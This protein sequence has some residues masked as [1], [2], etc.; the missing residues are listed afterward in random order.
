VPGERERVALDELRR[1][2]E[3]AR[4]L[5][6]VE[7]EAARVVARQHAERRDSRPG[8]L[9]GRRAAEPQ[10]EQALAPVEILVQ[11]DVRLGDESVASRA[12]LFALE[13][14]VRAG[15][16]ADEHEHEAG[17]RDERRREH[18]PAGVPRAVPR[19]HAGESR[20]GP[21]EP[22]APGPAAPQREEREPREQQRRPAAER[23]RGVV[24]RARRSRVDGG[25]EPQDRSGHGH[26]GSQAPPARSSAGGDR[27]GEQTL[28]RFADEP[29]HREPDRAEHDEDRDREA[30]GQGPRADVQE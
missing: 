30:D 8:Q 7:V 13:V 2:A 19:G 15:A 27:A 11:P 3:D 28:R 21:S 29:A 12:G 6:T 14:A 17:R 5:R 20:P 26:D 10:L 24:C 22:A 25:A 16:R 18:A 1:R 4:T 9:V 23:E